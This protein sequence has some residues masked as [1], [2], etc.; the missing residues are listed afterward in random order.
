MVGTPF[1]E[2]LAKTW[3]LWYGCIY[4]TIPVTI[5]VKFIGYA[6]LVI[7]AVCGNENTALQVAVATF[8][9]VLVLS[10]KTCL[11]RFGTVCIKHLPQTTYS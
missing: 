5:N 3:G 4:S 10:G 6:G 7:S 2:S 1:R 8:Y 9:P 11:E